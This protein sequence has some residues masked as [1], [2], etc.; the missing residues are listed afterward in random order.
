MP[1]YSEQWLTDRMTGGGRR[2]CAG[3]IFTFPLFSPFLVEH[4]KLTAPRL[5]TIV[6]A[7]MI[8]QYP[9]AA[10][11]GKAIDLYGPWSCSLASS[12]LFSLG[13]G[14]FA[15]EIY[16]TLDD[17]AAPSKSSFERLTLYYFLAG[18]GTVTSYFSSL[19]AASKNFPEYIGIASGVT[20]AIFGLSP[21]FFSLIAST[22]F[23]D[24][25]SELDVMHF[26]TFMAILTGVV[27]LIGA[28][29]LQTTSLTTAEIVSG[30]EDAEDEE[31]ISEQTADER[32]SLI[33]PKK[34]NVQVTVVPIEHNQSLIDILNDRYFWLLGL[35]LIICVGSCE[36]IMSNL[37]SIVM[38][39]PSSS[40]VPS[41]VAT[42]TQV[43]LLS[44][45][46]TITRLVVG[47]L[48]DFASPMASFLPNGTIHYT[49]KH[50]ISRVAFLSGA[51]MLLV[52]TYTW[53]E[54]GVR[55]RED[56]WVL[57][58]G[59]GIA[60]GTIFTTLPG[61]VSGVWGLSNLGRN[62]GIITY[63]PF[64]GTPLFSYLF[65]F[66]SAAHA[67]D[68]GVCKGEQCW[69]LT[70]AVTIISA[71]VS[72]FASVLLWRKWKGRV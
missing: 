59:T 4:F 16:K 72:L 10:F 3:G 1:S 17:I 26:I 71:A 32:T 25:G 21:V 19:F 58:V 67:S 36:M 66:V 33:T 20:M 9:F 65:A 57:S 56:V 68:G 37:G 42:A 48:A 51:S 69:R 39:L 60:Y 28:I 54:L 27:H 50:H 38:T 43:R 30:H 2:L 22:F 6:L 64:I 31:N 34:L 12:V 45:S 41:S 5:T 55:S 24:E 63:A 11:V 47:P 44:L 70:F 7:G 23:T 61:V 18:L 62:F 40:S 13:F 15:H 53:M 8:G 14:L 35:A 49:R 52:L 46:N 29:N